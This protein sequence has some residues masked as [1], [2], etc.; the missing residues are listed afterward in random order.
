MAHKLSTP[1]DRVIWYAQ[2]KDP[3]LVLY[4]Q[5][6]K[7][8]MVSYYETA[9]QV[10]CAGVGINPLSSKGAVAEDVDLW[11]RFASWLPA[12]IPIIGH[13]MGEMSKIVSDQAVKEFLNPCIELCRIAPDLDIWIEIVHE[14]AIDIVRDANHAKRMKN[15]ALLKK[16]KAVRDGTDQPQ[17][18]TL[19]TL[20]GIQDCAFADARAGFHG[21][22][23]ETM[24]ASN[25]ASQLVQIAKKRRQRA[26]KKEEDKPPVTLAAVAVEQLGK[27]A[28]K[29][30][31]AAANQVE[32]VV[33]KI[34][35][36]AK[37]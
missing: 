35:E 27:G 11:A 12:F 29:L 24:T 30:K 32:K 10:I 6:Y 7:M 28:E 17:I 13:G 19:I 33:K 37:P 22:S 31:E 5:T 14:A 21:L 1:Q 26:R 36:V 4:C 16:K 2:V 3:S 20:G 18:G 23:T 15:E 9:W 34:E 8:V 25:C